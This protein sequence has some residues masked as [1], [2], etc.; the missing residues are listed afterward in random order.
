P[1]AGYS[2]KI[3]RKYSR[4]FGADLVFTEMVSAEGLIHSTKRTL[5]LI[6]IS[7]DE[8]PVGIQ[9][10]TSSPDY[11][12]KSVQLIADIGY[13]VIDVNIGC[14]VRKVIQKGAGS[15]LLNTPIL[16]TE[17]VS[18]ALSAGL[19]VSVKIRCGFYSCSQW[20]NVLRLMEK[21]QKLGVSFITVHPR[22]ARQLFAGNADWYLVKQAVDNL[23]IPI[24]GS[25]D[26]F[27][28][29]DVKEK[30]TLTNPAG[31]MLA[32]GAIANF[33]LFSQVKAF[34][35]GNQIP[36]YEFT[37]RLETMRKFISDEVEF[38]GENRAIIWCRKLLIKLFHN[39]PD[40]SVYRRN[41]ASVN[42]LKQINT[43]FD[44]IIENFNGANIKNHQSNSASSPS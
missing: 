4:R 33:E 12:Q 17:V 21:F 1:L 24:I 43:I 40:A 44:E 3:Y 34:F 29:Q 5:K 9:F 15:A 36:H 25:G 28:I 41:I 31:V 37:D 14:S 13:S 10:F 27:S 39:I 35:E 42:T 26:L 22:S 38:R 20:E 8:Y 18:A 11:M 32:R 30:V 2:D 16:A 7:D 6:E 19:P 23:D